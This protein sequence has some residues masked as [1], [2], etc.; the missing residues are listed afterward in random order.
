MP[1]YPL[2][3]IK[4]NLYT[5]GS[6]Y[7]L[8]STREPYTGYYYEVSDGKRYTGKTIQ[9]GPNNLL[10]TNNPISSLST[11][12]PNSVD[13]EETTPLYVN[14]ML[15]NVNEDPDS[16]I[17]YPESINN[18]YFQ[19]NKIKS[20]RRIL[21]QPNI[22]PPNT[23][24]YSLGVYRRFFCKKNNENIYFE[25]DKSTHQ[26]LIQKHPSIAFDLY[27]S[28]STLW[29]LKGKQLKIYKS[30]KGLIELIERNQKWLGF[31]QYFNNYLQFYQFKNKKNLYTSGGKF[32]TKT[33][34]N[35]IGF[36]HTHNGLP[37]V[38]KIHTNTSHQI[39]IPISSSTSSKLDKTKYVTNTGGSSMSGGGGYMSGG[40]SY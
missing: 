30:N 38:G 5:N 9:D 28:I 4:P 19:L 18:E 13:D 17:P 27:S 11:D 20:V 29:Y 24:D 23:Q 16:G 1:Y 33:I 31:P 10:I 15:P 25:I 32:K 8:F 22:I 26:K 40:G 3:Q 2:S 34:P 12:P 39:L 37:M 35:Y 21:P 36:Y 14:I 6:E 7:V